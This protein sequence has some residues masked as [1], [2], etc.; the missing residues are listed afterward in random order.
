MKIKKG[1]KLRKVIDNFVVV[2][3]EDAAKEFQGM[4]HLN[5]TS[6]FLWKLIEDGL[7]DKNDLAK[8][9]VDHYEVDHQTALKDVNEFIN[10]LKQNN[11]LEL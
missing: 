7:T 11:V 6:A 5:E 4:I 8:M 2:P 1:F 9:L 10:I 3:L